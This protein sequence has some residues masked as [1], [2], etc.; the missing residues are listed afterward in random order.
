MNKFYLQ[1]GESG[2]RINIDVYPPQLANREGVLGNR[3]RPAILVACGGSGKD[4]AVGKSLIG[5]LAASYHDLGESFSLAGFWT[6]I[7]S[8]RGDPQRTVEGSSNLAANFSKRLPRQLFADE[9]PNQGSYSHRKHVAE[10]R[11]LVENLSENFGPDLD[12]SRIGV[13]GDSAGGGV[14]LALSAELNARVASVAL[15]G[16]ALRASQWF[17]GHKADSFFQEILDA[18][19]VRYDRETFL[20]ELCDAVDFVDKVAAPMMFG[21]AVPDPYALVPSKPDKWSSIG[22]QIEL[23]RCAIRSRY[24]KV[25]GV[26]GAEHT[27]YREHPAW[28]PYISALTAWFEETLLSNEQTKGIP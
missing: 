11:W 13:L 14:A 24:G 27:M 8:R 3:P 7:P 12:S 20:L 16:G 17:T 2:E 23:M 25:L 6:I 19:A 10:L 21:C 9:G 1:I 26:K 22:E 5:K 18:S 15:W 4:P 28:P